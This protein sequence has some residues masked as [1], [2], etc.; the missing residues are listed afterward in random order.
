MKLQCLA[1]KTAVLLGSFR[2]VALL[3]TESFGSSLGKGTLFPCN[4][5]ER[6]EACVNHQGLLQTHHTA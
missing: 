6:A 5:K 1:V 3:S 2:V 4:E